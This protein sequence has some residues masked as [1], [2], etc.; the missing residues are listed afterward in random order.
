M[1]GPEPDMPLPQADIIMASQRM[2]IIATAPTP[3]MCLRCAH[4]KPVPNQP[5]PMR[6]AET[7]LNRS[8]REVPCGGMVIPK[9]P[10]GVDVLVETVTVVLA[11]A[12]GAG[13]TVEGAN[14]HDVPGGVPEQANV[15]GALKPINVFTLTTTVAVCPAVTETVVGAATS[16][17]SPP[18]EPAEAGEIAPKSP[19]LSPLGPA[20][21]YNVL[22]SPVPFCPKIISQRPGFAIALPLAFLS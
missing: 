16:A 7:K 20:L 4:P 13:V 21:K 1:L 19:L 18:G 8:S 22:G 12:P 9:I 6:T 17:K 2:L 11:I 3:T 14:K 15:T 5:M 10:T